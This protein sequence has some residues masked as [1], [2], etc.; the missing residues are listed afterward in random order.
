MQK[1][2]SKQHFV[3]TNNASKM[4]ANAIVNTN[5]FLKSKH[6]ILA[7]WSGIYTG[8]LSLQ[9][10]G[11]SDFSLSPTF[12]N[13]RSFQKLMAFT[14]QKHFYSPQPSSLPRNV[15]CTIA[16]MQCKQYSYW[17][18]FYDKMNDTFNLATFGD[19]TVFTVLKGGRVLL[20]QRL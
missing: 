4:I 16:Y 11:D 1:P 2:C 17:Q 13:E 3:T 6:I 20:F 19:G 7:S 15:Q 14:K 8:D 10:V 9:K 18:R 12:C 5:M